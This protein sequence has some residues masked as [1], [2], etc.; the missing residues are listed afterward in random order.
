MKQKLF[1]GGLLDSNVYIVWNKKEAMIIDCG[2]FPRAVY[3]FVRE[4]ELTVKYIVLTH[5]HYDHIDYISE[6]VKLFPNAKILCHE[7]ELKV[8]LDPEANLSSYF[9]AP[10]SYEHNYS[11]L[12]S[13]DEIE[14]DDD[15]FSVFS[16]PGHTPG[17]ICLHNKKDNILYTGDVVFA[18]GYG[19]TDFKHGD[20][21]ALFNS[22]RSI[23]RLFSGATIY[24]GH[25]PNAKI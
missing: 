5:G 23:I 4:N 19:R 20:T 13:G 17:C 9:G 1:S 7:D 14:L 24:P 12:N 11:L 25:G 18:N 3:D 6:Y 8:I 22:L 2:V 16:A 15:F 10:K 21:T